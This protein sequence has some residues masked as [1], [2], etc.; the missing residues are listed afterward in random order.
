LAIFDTAVE[1]P[2]P[3]WRRYVLW[4]VGVLVT[5]AVFVAAFPDYLWYPFVYYKEVSTADH[6]INEVVGGQFQQAYQTWK[7]AS[8]YTFQDFMEDWGA[9]GYYGPVKS[10]RLG[11]PEHVKNSSAAEIVLEV[12][13]YQPFPAND[14]LRA[15][16]N[17]E[18]R[19]WVE[20]RDQS[21][22]FPP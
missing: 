21:M 2:P 6:F 10:F 7:P 8:S 9:N 18:V 4:A 16:R 3:K 20:F 12:S 13:P 5:L 15:T 1:K 14:P 17:K 19:I 22:S 11:R